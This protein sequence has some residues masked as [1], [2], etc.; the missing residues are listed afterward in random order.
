MSNVRRAL[1]ISVTW[2]YIVALPL[3]AKPVK[4]YSAY[5]VAAKHTILLALYFSFWWPENK[6]LPLIWEARLQRNFRFFS[7]VHPSISF[8][9]C[10]CRG[11]ISIKFRSLPQI[12]TETKLENCLSLHLCAHVNW[13][14][15]H[16]VCSIWMTP[17][18]RIFSF[19]C[20]STS[21]ATTTFHF[22]HK[23]NMQN[24]WDEERRKNYD[25][26][27]QFLLDDDVQC[28]RDTM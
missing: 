19:G 5:V 3:R 24:E 6:N 14:Y 2:V 10:S 28:V 8:V 1:I 16:R 18:K 26:F 17:K 22:T 9:I 12:K 25:I 27:S 23:L 7:Y 21:I 20:S 15:V 11:W 4:T 13:S